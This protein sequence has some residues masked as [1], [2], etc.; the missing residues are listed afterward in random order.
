[1][2]YLIWLLRCFVNEKNLINNYLLTYLDIRHKRLP[3]TPHC[4]QCA[5]RQLKQH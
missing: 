4:S 3:S 2:Q 1:M 5:S